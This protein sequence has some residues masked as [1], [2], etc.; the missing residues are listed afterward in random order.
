MLVRGYR[1]EDN[2]RDESDRQ[3]EKPRPA[4]GVDHRFASVLVMCTGVINRVV[5]RIS[6]RTSPQPGVAGVRQLPVGGHDRAHRR[7]VPRHSYAGGRGDP[8]HP[9]G[10]ALAD[11]ASDGPRVDSRRSHRA[12]Y[13]GDQSSPGLATTCSATAGWSRRHRSGC[14]IVHRNA[15][16]LIAQGAL[17]YLR[18]IEAVSRAPALPAALVAQIPTTRKADPLCLGPLGSCLPARRFLWRSCWSADRLASS[19]SSTR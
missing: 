12:I 16:M 10:G 3:Q 14:A 17:N 18:P 4:V 8:R 9:H 11:A 2:Q 15:Q 5:M 6:H 19:R 13:S 7:A 1:D